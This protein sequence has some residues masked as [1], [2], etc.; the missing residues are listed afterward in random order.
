MAMLLTVISFTFLFVV[1][2]GPIK[3]LLNEGVYFL[4][5]LYSGLTNQRFSFY[6]AVLL[7]VER[8]WTLILPTWKLGYNDFIVGKTLPFS[9][10][11][12]FDNQTL[13]NSAHLQGFR[14][15]NNLPPTRLA[16]CLTQLQCSSFD[17]CKNP[18]LHTIDGLA[19]AQNVVCLNS[20]ASYY[21]LRT[22]AYTMY[23]TSTLYDLPILQ[24]LRNSM[25]IQP[26]F[27]QIALTVVQRLEKTYGSK[28]FVSVHL[29][30]EMDFQVSCRRFAKKSW[31]D[32]TEK[33]A[34]NEG[35]D[36]IYDALVHEK[37]PFETVLLIM[38]GEKNE[39]FGTLKKLCGKADCHVSA[40]VKLP[41][42]CRRSFICVRKENFWTA[43][44]APPGFV[45]HEMSLAMVDYA[46]ANKSTLFL[47]NLYSTMSKEIYYSFI[48]A[49]RRALMYNR[50]CSAFKGGKCP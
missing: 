23:N 19:K 30:N 16:S 44:D 2:G 33:R 18:S 36:A 41:K 49:N 21:Q 10:F 6:H 39:Y 15:V 50:P 42:H 20:D 47:G 25:V 7:A 28:E 43:E 4:P 26:M 34:C 9:Y 1:Q 37:V 3:P 11:Y 12:E 29:R 31:N 24:D 27:A 35:E 5:G 8:K 40:G 14:Y 17:A 38:N 13:A 48:S 46:L 32:S 22:I 45:H